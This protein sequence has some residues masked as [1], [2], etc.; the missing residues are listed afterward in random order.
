MAP[1]EAVSLDGTLKAAPAGGADNG[2]AL[3]GLEDVGADLLSDFQTVEALYGNLAEV[4]EGAVVLQMAS[5]GPVELL[6]GTE[7]NLGAFVAVPFGGP[8]LRHSA[9]AGLYDGDG[10]H[11][12]VFINILGHAQ[13]FS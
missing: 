10:H 11:S 8:E 6:L 3:T 2:N 12:S 7:A 13:L 1:A 4:S 9:G 5:L